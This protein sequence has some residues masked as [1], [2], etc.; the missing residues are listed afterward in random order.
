[1]NTRIIIAAAIASFGSQLAFGQAGGLSAGNDHGRT[2][3]SGLPPRT[4]GLQSQQMTTTTTKKTV[5]PVG[6]KGYLDNVIGNSKDHKFHMTVNGKDLP[7]T[8]V[9]FHEEQKLGAG[10]SATAVDMKGVDG[11]VYEMNFVTSGGVV[12]GG[13]IVKINGKAL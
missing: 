13:K 3:S 6:V 7:L 2:E 10:K 4:T 12:A 9:K 1:M 11:K 8:P 5:L